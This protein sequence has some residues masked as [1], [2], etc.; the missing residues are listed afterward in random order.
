MDLEINYYEK[1]LQR[2]LKSSH[3]ESVMWLKFWFIEYP[4]MT[5][6]EKVRYWVNSLYMGNYL[7]DLLIL[8]RYINKSNLNT[9]TKIEPNFLKLWP[10]IG[11]K[12][13]L[14]HH[15]NKI[16][17]Q[18]DDDEIWNFNTALLKP[19]AF[20]FLAYSELYKSIFH[21]KEQRLTPTSYLM[22]FVSKTNENRMKVSSI[23]LCMAI[24]CNLDEIFKKPDEIIEEFFRESGFLSEEEY[25]KEKL[26]MKL[27][28]Y[29]KD[30]YYLLE[31]D[32][33]DQFDT[34][35]Q[36]PPEWLIV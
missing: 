22:E 7:E 21:I 15:L 16:Y 19:N 36:S 5:E 11:L 31:E 20:I 8:T 13:E 27:S 30:L 35:I 25:S 18:K 4:I 17:E 34:K 26:K 23:L 28:L 14:D 1:D 29:F 12:L 2:Y 10:E 24:L 9:W 32:P 3:D 6:S 33:R